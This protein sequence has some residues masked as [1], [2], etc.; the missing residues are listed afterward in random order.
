MVDM[1]SDVIDAVELYSNIP[2]WRADSPQENIW[3]LASQI[4]QLEILVGIALLDGLRILGMAR[5]ASA[6]RD[7][8]RV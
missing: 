6:F 4:Q 7:E 5:G 1:N 3:G 8:L 2:G